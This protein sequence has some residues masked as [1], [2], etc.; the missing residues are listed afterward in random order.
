MIKDWNDLRYLLALQEGGTMK[1]AAE[2]LHTSAST[3]SR[4]I[5]HLSENCGDMLVQPTKGE[6]WALTPLALKL[7]AVARGF[8]EDL[9]LLNEPKSEQSLNISITSLDFVLTY[10]LAPELKSARLAM[11]H[12][13][14]SLL[15]SDKRL[16][17]AF[18]EADV[19][20]RFGRPDE[21]QLVSKRVASVPFRIWRNK[22]NTTSDWVGMIEAF[23]WTPDMQLAYQVFGKPPLFRASSYAAAKKAAVS[24]GVNTIGPDAVLAACSKFEKDDTIGPVDRELWRVIH[25]SRRL[26]KNLQQFN[27]WLDELFAAKK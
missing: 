3:V 13:N 18:G 5:Q 24:I 1:R 12:L 17:L 22:Q 16:S 9:S 10:F 6:V 4:H 15:S 19:A 11:P 27:A 8:D 21:G 2:L 23:D 26:D 14:L 25:E 20:L 7:T